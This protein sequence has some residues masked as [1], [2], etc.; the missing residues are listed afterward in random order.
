MTYLPQS[1]TSRSETSLRSVSFPPPTRSHRC[2]AEGLWVAAV[3]TLNPALPLIRNA[4]GVGFS[5]F[6]ALVSPAV[7]WRDL[8][9][10]VR[11]TSAETRGIL[12][13]LPHTISAGISFICK[14]LEH[15]DYTCSDFLSPRM[16]IKISENDIS[17]QLRFPTIQIVPIPNRANYT[18]LCW[19][20]LMNSKVQVQRLT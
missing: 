8:T 2:P 20:I 12:Y 3:L 9:I 6:W 13:S 5:P 14:C 18:S 1:H 7:K 17:R 10:L 11:I 16:S 15:R 19:T 4:S